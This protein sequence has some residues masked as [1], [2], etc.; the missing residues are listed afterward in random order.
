MRVWEGG[1]CTGCGSAGTMAQHSPK[2]L[3]KFSFHATFTVWIIFVIQLKQGV[4]T[5]YLNCNYTYS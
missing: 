3:E 1:V 2:Y 5:L 4:A